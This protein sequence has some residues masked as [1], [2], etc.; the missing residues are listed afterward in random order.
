MAHTIHLSYHCFK[1]KNQQAMRDL[2]WLV[3][4]IKELS[5]NVC[6]SLE[7][8]GYMYIFK[9]SLLLKILI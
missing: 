2:S 9:E 3:G 8:C 4:A 7:Y 1:K 5:L 6:M